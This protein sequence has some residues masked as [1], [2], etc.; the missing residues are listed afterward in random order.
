MDGYNYYITEDSDEDIFDGNSSD[1][2]DDVDLVFEGTRHQKKQALQRIIKGECS[3]SE[4]EF[5]DLMSKKLDDKIG[6]VERS[7]LSRLKDQKKDED[8]KNDPEMKDEDLLFDPNADDED[9]IWAKQQK[10]RF[11]SSVTSSPSISFFVVDNR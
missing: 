9:E 5:E 1:E 10:S 2:V 8:Q 7:F 11:P 4:D 6:E 3:S